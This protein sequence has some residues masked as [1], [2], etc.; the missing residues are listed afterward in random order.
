VLGRANFGTRVPVTLADGRAST[1]VTYGDSAIIV[2][3]KDGSVERRIAPAP[4]DSGMVVINRPGEQFRFAPVPFRRPPFIVTAAG[5]DRIAIATIVNTSG[6]SGTYRVTVLRTT[7]ETVYSKTFPFTAA[8]ITTAARDS[9][10]ARLDTAY[11]RGSRMAE[12]NVE[13][14]RLLH[15]RTPTSMAPFLSPYLGDDGSVWLRK[16]LPDAAPAEYV[17]LTPNGTLAPVVRLPGKLRLVSATASSIW[18]TETDAD[19][20]VSLVRLNVAQPNDK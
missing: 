11:G 17:V 3:G 9:A 18:A 2:L 6:T 1:T 20:F 13:L 12:Q 14:L 19:G 16:N 4:P 5:G 15:E 7:G 10:W 8:P